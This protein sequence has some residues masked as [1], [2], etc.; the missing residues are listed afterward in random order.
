MNS[1]KLSRSLSES[2]LL[3]RKSLYKT[4]EPRIDPFRFFTTNYTKTPALKPTCHKTHIPE[5]NIQTVASTNIKPV[6]KLKIEITKTTSSI[7][8]FKQPR[9][10]ITTFNPSFS[11]KTYEKNSRSTKADQFKPIFRGRIVKKIEAE[12]ITKIPSLNKKILKRVNSLVFKK[13]RQYRSAL[14]FSFADPD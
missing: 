14:D 8:N 12:P 10:I 13:K 7:F 2:C 5:K 6:S 4:E 9:K 11:A 1:L 3:R